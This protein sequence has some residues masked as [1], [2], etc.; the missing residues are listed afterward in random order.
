MTFFK[1]LGPKNLLKN[2]GKD[3]SDAIDA[4]KQLRNI[5]L[6]KFYWF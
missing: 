4:Y 5:C 6:K 3:P 1:I 2:Q